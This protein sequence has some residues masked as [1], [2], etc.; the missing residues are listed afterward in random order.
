MPEG[1]GVEGI[2]YSLAISIRQLSPST[3]SLS[4]YNRYPGS[5]EPEFANYS[6]DNQRIFDEFISYRNT[7][8][9]KNFEKM[10]NEYPINCVV[11]LNCVDQEM[12]KIG[13]KKYT[14]ISYQNS[15]YIYYR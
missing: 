4:A 6:A 8:T 13:M 2:T 1:I 9:L 14:G 3:V 12:Q 11:T 7:E 15:Y 5:I 10:L